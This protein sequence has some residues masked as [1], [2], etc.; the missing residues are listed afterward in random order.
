M[1][2]HPACKRGM[3]DTDADAG[4]I[5]TNR[6]RGVRVQMDREG[7]RARKSGALRIGQ[8]W[9]RPCRVLAQ[10]W[11]SHSDASLQIHTNSADTWRQYIDAG[12]AASKTNLPTSERVD[13]QRPDEQVSQGARRN[14][15]R[16]GG[17]C[18]ACGRRSLE[19]GGEIR[20]RGQYGHAR[21]GTRT[22]A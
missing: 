8:N 22:A 12:A 9:S 14:V 19:G 3:R 13:T 11:F 18:G 1:L 20:T 15:H 2:E 5:M 10:E 17:V 7:E 16:F 6:E 21:C 4:C